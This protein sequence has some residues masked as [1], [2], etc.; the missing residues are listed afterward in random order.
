PRLELRSGPRRRALRAVAD[1]RPL[2][3]RRRIDSAASGGAGVARVVV[4]GGAGFLGSHLVD[5]LLAR[6]DEVVVI[7]NLLTGSRANLARALE[8]HGFRFVEADVCTEL[9]IDGPVDLV[10]H[11]ASAA[12]PP[13]YLAHPIATLD[14]GSLGTRRMLDLAQ[15]HDA[16][17]VLASTSEVY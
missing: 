15:A 6:G 3:G 9:A 7:D 4:T 1:R 14:A 16:R 12:S 8:H 17:F 2:P 11:F 13:R 10:L 5:A